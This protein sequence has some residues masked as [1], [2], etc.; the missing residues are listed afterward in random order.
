LLYPQALA[1]TPRVGPA[2][3][4]LIRQITTL[5]PQLDLHRNFHSQASRAPT[6]RYHLRE[7]AK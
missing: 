3:K 5:W 6:A 1:L 2:G 4:S 7:K